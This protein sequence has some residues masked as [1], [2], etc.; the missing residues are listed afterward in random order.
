MF[1]C[2]WGFT[3]N[4]V[5]TDKSRYGHV[6]KKIM[7]MK[8]LYG[9]TKSVSH[10]PSCARLVGNKVRDGAGINNC[11]GSQLQCAISAVLQ[12]GLPATVAEPSKGRILLPS[13]CR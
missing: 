1:I 2:F 11:S 13:R 4:I 7:L 9:P 5:K 3:W 8:K 6:R 12:A 10:G